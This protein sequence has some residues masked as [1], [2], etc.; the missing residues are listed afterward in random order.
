MKKAI[1]LA[2]LVCMVLSGSAMAAASG[3]STYTD[4]YGGT[5]AQ[6]NNPNPA[7]RLHLRTEPRANATSLGKYYNGVTV[8]I[9]GYPNADWV[10]VR[11]QGIGGYMLKQYLTGS[12]AT[13]A[14]PV[15]TVTADQAH[16]RAGMSDTS[17]SLGKV[18]KGTQV[19]V[20]GIGTTWHHVIVNGVGSGYMMV[21][22]LT[23][24]PEDSSGGGSTSPAKGWLNVNNPVATDRLHLRTAPKASAES[25]GK[26]YNGVTV[27]VLS[28]PNNDWAKVRVGSTEGYMQR[29]F[30]TTAAVKSAIPMLTVSNNN[31]TDRLNLR[32]GMS[33]T[34][35]SLGK[36]GNGTKVEVLGIGPTWYHVR[37][38][39]K[40]GYMMAKYLSPLASGGSGTGTSQS[41]G[42]N[43]NPSAPLGLIPGNTKNVVI[44]YDQNMKH[45][46]G[47]ADLDAAAAAITAMFPAQYPGCEL[48]KLSYNEAR[49]DALLPRFYGISTTA[50]LLEANGKL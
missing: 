13:Y 28:Y 7:D 19:T 40:I 30:L 3:F 34:S 37:V 43:P 42:S 35:A 20:L 17:A 4:S 18:P 25:L 39:G 23:P 44:S 27:E 22:H 49:S 11:I 36:Y 45:P 38:D 1:C 9:I 47:K 29:K 48:L 26:Y 50:S 10:K 32:A 14:T 6:V 46:F 15:V 33:E 16:L 31:P 41:S 21:K 8:E 12:G 5:F 2:L 24:V